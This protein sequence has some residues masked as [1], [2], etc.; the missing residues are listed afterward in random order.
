MV[1]FRSEHGGIGIVEFCTG[2]G[3]AGEPSSA[4]KIRCGIAWKACG[5]SRCGKPAIVG[6]IRVKAPVE[7]ARTDV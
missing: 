5:V 1:R 7:I 3:F 6:E 4:L 2:C